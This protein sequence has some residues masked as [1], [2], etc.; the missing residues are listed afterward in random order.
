MSF[1]WTGESQWRTVTTGESVQS[2]MQLRSAVTN[3]AKLDIVI[4]TT[5]SLREK[6]FIPTVS[7]IDY[8]DG[9]E[10]EVNE[11]IN[12]PTTPAS[13]TEITSSTLIA[14][15]NSEPP[16]AQTPDIRDK[17][18]EATEINPI[19]P[20]VDNDITRIDDNETTSDTN[21]DNPDDDDNELENVESNDING[22]DESISE[23]IHADPENDVDDDNEESN[24]LVY[25]TNDIHMDVRVS[26]TTTTSTTTTTTI[27]PQPQQS[28]ACG[29]GR[30]E[31]DHGCRMLYDDEEDA[32]GRTE[33]FCSVGFTLDVDDGRT[34]HGKVLRWI[35]RCVPALFNLITV[36]PHYNK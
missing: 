24:D 16:T 19:E 6:L 31:C 2:R 13:V 9:R 14:T 12:P 21:D 33:C 25:E 26:S 23:N 11:E 17:N 15:T 35:R 10:N 32:V 5:F 22:I 4:I 28:A 20:E 3:C 34:C 18:T 1:H 7:F 30:N 29:T 36:L 27:A 8:D